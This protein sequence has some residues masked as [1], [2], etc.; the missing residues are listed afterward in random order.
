MSSVLLSQ[1]FQTAV[2]SAAAAAS[3]AAQT[4]WSA[5]GEVPQPPQQQQ[6]PY[7]M[8]PLQQ[9]Y[10][11]PQQPYHQPQRAAPEVLS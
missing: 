2:A 3:W 7:G 10:A 6:Q 5:V 9:P 1:E 11:M 8:P 4:N